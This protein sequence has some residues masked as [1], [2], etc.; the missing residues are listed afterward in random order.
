MAEERDLPPLPERLDPQKNYNSLLSEYQSKANG[1]SRRT[2]TALFSMVV[3]IILPLGLLKFTN[4]VLALA[5]PLL[6]EYLVCLIE[7]FTKALRI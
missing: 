7:S 5:Q 2:R 1:Q 6:L 4:D 3:K